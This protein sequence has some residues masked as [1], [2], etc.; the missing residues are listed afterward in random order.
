MICIRLAWNGICLEQLGG[1]INFLLIGECS[2]VC[3]PIRYAFS[4]LLWPKQEIDPVF[5]I[6]TDRCVVYPRGFTLVV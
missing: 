5:N 6:V 4:R 1:V 2:S 3:D